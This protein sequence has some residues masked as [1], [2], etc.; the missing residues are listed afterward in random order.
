M[1]TPT[2]YKSQFNYLNIIAS[3]L[4]LLL[5]FVL[6]FFFPAFF[7]FL[8]TEP[9]ISVLVLIFIGIPF[10]FIT[11]FTIGHFYIY[12]ER[13]IS[14]LYL[15]KLEDEE[16]C[17]R[18]IFKTYHIQLKEIRKIKF[19]N[20]AHL[21]LRS[22]KPGIKIYGPKKMS[23]ELYEQYYTNTR[24]L[25]LIFDYKLKAKIHNHLRSED[26]EKAET[27]EQTNK[28]ESMVSLKQSPFKSFDVV[29]SSGMLVLL[30]VVIFIMSDELPALL[31]LFLL[32]ITIFLF[33]PYKYLYYFSVSDEVIEVSH[34]L[35]P[36]FKKSFYFKKLK[37]IS[38]NYSG[39]QQ[40]NLQLSIYDEHY[41]LH[42]FPTE[43]TSLGNF[44]KILDLANLHLVETE[45]W[46]LL[47]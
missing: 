10:S 26:F 8:C 18:N 12:T 20:I 29:L 37:K 41:K 21:D 15:I 47:K 35:K 45:G 33:S 3:I 43:L 27:F 40:V 39:T 44:K 46:Y 25:K 31:I 9:D 24:E 6:S 28:N 2:I 11:L 19:E 17:L 5:L 13:L 14:S 38:V 7:V 32:L 30:V 42:S 1:T 36:N 22:S 4:Y 23:I 16:L 34:L